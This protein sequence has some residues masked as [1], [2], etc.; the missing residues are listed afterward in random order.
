MKVEGKGGISAK[1]IA[2][3]ISSV[4]GKRITTF[5]LEYPRFIHAEFLT[6]RQFS[7]NAASSRAIPIEKVIEQVE[8]NP[9][10][11]IHWGK[12]QS[13]MQA[14]EEVDQHD[15]NLAIDHWEWCIADSITGAEYLS[16]IGLH[17]QVVN[18]TLE[19]YQFIKVVCTAT[20]FDN[21]FWL[22]CHEDAQPEIK[23]LADCMY[24]AY[25]SN[26]P[27]GLA[28]GEWHT[29]YVGHMDGGGG[30]LEY[31]IE[32]EDGGPIFLTVGE[33]LKVSASCCAQVSYRKTDTSLEKALKIYDSLVSSKPVHASPFEH[34]ASPI[35]YGED[36][37][38]DETWWNSWQDGITHQDKHGQFW[39][40]NLCGWIQYRQKIDDNV[41]TN[42]SG[43][44]E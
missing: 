39:S 27:F 7:R 6:H 32:D 44:S 20:E 30:Q 9:A 13:G 42:Y 10:M 11:P 40:G 35:S 29:P 23:E 25:M 17:K 31:Y 36:C 3:S 1:I 12:N 37:S 43:K 28:P 2:D 8:N 26:K 38:F 5:E 19:P 16:K 18:R 4:N 15:I 14:K 41:C 33:A 24:K 22:R 34:Q 21:F